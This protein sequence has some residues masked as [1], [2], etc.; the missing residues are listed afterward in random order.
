MLGVGL[1]GAVFRRDPVDDILAIGVRRVLRRRGHRGG[2]GGDRLRLGGDFG[3]TGRGRLPRLDLF[4][5]GVH[6]LRVLLDRWRLVADPDQRR[7]HGQHG[8]DAAGHLLALRV[9]VLVIEDQDNQRQ[10]GNQGDDRAELVL[11]E[12]PERVGF[13]GRVL[14]VGR[15]PEQ[16]AGDGEDR[17][18]DQD[19]DQ[20]RQV[21][22]VE[23][24]LVEQYDPGDLAANGDDP[25]KHGEQAQ[26][27]GA[28][29]LA[30]RCLPVLGTVYGRLVVG[31]D[32]IPR[33]R[34][35]CGA[36][37]KAPGAASLIERRLLRRESATADPILIAHDG[38]RP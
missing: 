19:A 9:H 32:Q 14:P 1:G 4:R 23:L 34:H 15:L 6:V 10:E 25:R 37:S 38:I 12:E 36:A 17:D 26:P 28:G 22:L 33:C 7:Q 8:A 21:A 2:V 20:Q 31:H 35:F 5:A 3:R 27:R 16:A 11:D 24:V 13:A 30:L 29:L 18:A